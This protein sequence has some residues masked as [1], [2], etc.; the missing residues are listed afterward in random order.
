MDA[1]EGRARLRATYSRR[2]FHLF[3][4]LVT[5]ALLYKRATKKI[6]KQP[7]RNKTRRKGHVFRV[8]SLPAFQPDDALN[9]AL[10]AI[11]DSNLSGEKVAVVEFRG[12]LSIKMESGK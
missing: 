5:A 6:L 12:G 7:W 1:G 8:T 11:I 2:G 3:V 9:T 4:F 10:K